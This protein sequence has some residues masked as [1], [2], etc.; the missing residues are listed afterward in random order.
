MTALRPPHGIAVRTDMPSA[1]HVMALRRQAGWRDVGLRALHVALRNSLQ[2]FCVYQDE[3]L[4][5][6]GRLVG[7][8]VLKVYVEELVVATAAR[9]QG[10]GS[11]ILI[12]MEAYTRAHCAAGCRL[13]LTS[14][15][16]YAGFYAKHGFE[17]RP[18]DM[19][20][21]QRHL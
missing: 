2:V 1:A 20:A 10:I 8:G 21:M 7:D 9:R 4:V 13:G 3:L 16:G 12:A 15:R 14:S 5:G 6:F 11:A 19:P 17:R 18:D